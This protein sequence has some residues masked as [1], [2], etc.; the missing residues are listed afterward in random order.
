MLRG[1]VR[2]DFL[3][4][5]RR[6]RVDLDEHRRPTGRVRG[7]LRKHTPFWHAAGFSSVLRDTRNPVGLAER[8]SGRDTHRSHGEQLRGDHDLHRLLQP[9]KQLLQWRWSFSDD[10]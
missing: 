4:Y 9:V 3:T 10:Y 6:E 8:R 2:R 1:G 7:I 5:L